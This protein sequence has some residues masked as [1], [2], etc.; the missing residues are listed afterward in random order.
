M[1]L[2]NIHSSIVANAS[3]VSGYDPANLR[4]VAFL[5]ES[6]ASQAPFG[7]AISSIIS[8]SLQRHFV[9][10]TNN[11]VHILRKKRLSDVIFK[12]LMQIDG[13]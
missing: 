6:C 8:S 1:R 12:S 2:M 3:I 9:V 11:G 13:L 4:N 5:S 10:L 7:P